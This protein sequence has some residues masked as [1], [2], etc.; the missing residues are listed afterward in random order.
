MPMMK[1]VLRFTLLFIPILPSLALA[2][3]L[4][5]EG[6]AP[7][8]F[9]LEQLLKSAV[10]SSEDLK[11]VELEI[12]ATEAEIRA[13]DLE[14]STRLQ[15][16]AAK[17]HE[18]REILNPIVLNSQEI[19]EVQAQKLFSTGT[20]LAARLGGDLRTFQGDPPREEAASASWEVSLSQDLWRNAFGR[21]TRLRQEGDAEELKS[22]RLELLARKQ[23]LLQNIETLYWDVAATQNEIRIANDNLRRSRQMASWVQDRTRRA[24]A[25]RIDLLQAEA[26]VANRQLQLQN[27]EDTLA[28][29]QLQLRQLLPNTTQWG[30]WQADQGTFQ[31]H[32]NL[33]SLLLA[34]GTSDPRRLDL[35][36]SEANARAQKA[37]A[38]QAEDLIRPNLDLQLLYGRNGLDREPSVALDELTSKNQDRTR[39][40][41]VFS[42]D[43]DR[44]GARSQARAANLRAEASE[45]RNLRLR[46]DSRMAWTDLSREITSLKTRLDTAKKLAT[47][48]SQKAQAERTRYEQGRSTAF[49]AITFEVEAAEAQIQVS[50]LTS[51]LR[52]AEGRVRLFTRQDQE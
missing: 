18:R 8:T 33:E 52:K 16:E 36:A 7:T 39:V 44:E 38:A 26:L 2:Q 50:R 24:A 13:R 30:A 42:M 1:S 6:P 41:L 5:K 10:E 51:N 32:R 14:L 49:Q 9:S 45:R 17:E 20:S 19:V 28:T 21:S 43:L 3:S 47:L 12:Q 22:R 25:E 11:S 31:A 40:G 23:T 29:T 15:V 27:L 34:P 37:R 46:E 35:L 4:S 48:Q